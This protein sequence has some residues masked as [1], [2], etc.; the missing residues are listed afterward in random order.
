MTSPAPPGRPEN[1]LDPDEVSQIAAIFEESDWL[2]LDVVVGETTIHLAR[3]DGEAVAVSSRVAPPSADEE[4]PGLVTVVTAPTLGIFWRSPHPGAVPFVSV[5]DAVE[6]G[7]TVGILEVMKLMTPLKAGAAG[8]VAAV[9]A[10]D[11]AA[12]E[13]GQGLLRIVAAEG[14]TSRG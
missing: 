2:E 8:V 1:A 13:S 5:G 9:L 11:G 3:S 10:E 7:T 6:P 4:A 14:M 12:V